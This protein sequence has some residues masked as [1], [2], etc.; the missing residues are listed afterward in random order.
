MLGV[1]DQGQVERPYLVGR[2]LLAAKH[3]QEVR[4]SREIG[5]RRDETLT[6]G[7]AI[8]IDNRQRN[9][10]E[11]SLGLANVRGGR[12][13]MDVRV[14]VAQHADRSSERVHARRLLRQGLQQFAEGAGQLAMAGETLAEFV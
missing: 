6:T 10:R 12:V 3:V 1:E 9:L 7:Q 8:L 5:P 2:R 13:V 14:K 11:Q 4:G